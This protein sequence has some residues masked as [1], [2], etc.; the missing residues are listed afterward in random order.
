MTMPPS[1]VT[2]VGQITGTSDLPFIGSH[3]LSSV[4]YQF[5]VMANRP[6]QS[7]IYRITDADTGPDLCLVVQITL[8][9]PRSPILHS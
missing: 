1:L 6:H 4:C 9:G 3:M 8:G 7:R 5:E 2:L